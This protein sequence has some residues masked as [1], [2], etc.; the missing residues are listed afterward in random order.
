V[1]PASRL[2]VEPTPEGQADLVLRGGGGNGDSGL[3][4]SPAHALLAR[5]APESASLWGIPYALDPDYDL[6][7]SGWGR[8]AMTVIDSEWKQ[9]DRLLAYRYLGAWNVGLLLV[10]K[11]PEEWAADVARDRAALPVRPFVNPFLLP[12]YR[13]VPRVVFHESSGSA[14]YVA[15]AG[16]YKALQEENCVREGV[17]PGIEDYPLPPQALKLVDEGGRI[18]LRYCAPGKAFF[19]VAMTYDEGWRASVDGAPAATYP[20]GLSQLGV[21]LPAG[22][23]G[24]LLEYRDPRVGAGAAVSLLAFAA[25]AAVFC[26]Q[27]RRAG[28][29]S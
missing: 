12:R 20:T 10:R 29:Q 21:E 9:P 23:H 14:L 25:C 3:Q 11:T 19:T 6:M 1:P 18:L 5:L 15:R 22:E 13:F 28:I 26:R 16:L 4:A 17:K 8:L 2:W 24:L 27:A 7:L